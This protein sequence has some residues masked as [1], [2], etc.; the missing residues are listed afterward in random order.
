MPIY[1]SAQNGKDW[2]SHISYAADITSLAQS[3]DRIY[4][5]TD[6]KLFIYNN[7][8][9]SLEEYIKYKGGNIDITH[10]AYNKKQKC[11]FLTRSDANIELLFEDG[12][13]SEIPDLKNYSSGQITDKTINSVFMDDDCAYLSTNFGFVTVNI[14]KKEIK[15]T[16]LFN[17]KFYSV[18]SYN[19]RLYATSEKGIFTVDMSENVQ[20]FINWEEFKVSDYYKENDYKFKDSDVKNIVLFQEKLHFLFPDSAVYIM[21]SSESVKGILKGAKPLVMYTSSN[22]HLMILNREKFWEYTDLSTQNSVNIN[23]LTYIIPD[24]SKQHEYWLSSSG[25]NLSQAKISENNLEYLQQY[26]TLSGP[27]SNYPFSQTMES[28]QLIVAGGG[29][30]YDRYRFPASV[31]I[32]KN[33]KW[34]NIYPSQINQESGVYT[35]DFGYAIS[36]PSNP[37]HIFA[38]SWG[39]GLYEFEDGHFKNRY[40]KT[41]TNNVIEEIQK[42]DGWTTT[43]IGGMAY[44]KNGNLWMVNSGVKNIVKVYLKNGTWEKLYYPEIDG[45]TV[46]TNSKKIY[47]DRYSNKWVISYA[48]ENRNYLLVFDDNGSIS[49]TSDDKYKTLHNGGFTDKNGN[50]ID[51]W[52]IHDI[53]EDNYGNIWLSTDIGPY[54]IANSKNITS[55]DKITLNRITIDKQTGSGSVTGLLE[56]AAVNSI[57]IDGAGRK[58]IA[59]QTSGAFLLSADNSEILEHFDTENSPLPSNNIVSLSI[60]ANGY[61]YF[62]SE[63]GLMSYR[64]G[65]T[66]GTEDFSNVYVYPNPVRPDYSGIITVTGLKSDSHIKITDVKGN[67]IIEGKS[68]GGQFIWDG[69]NAKGRRVDTGVYLVFGSTENG[70]EGVVTKIMVVK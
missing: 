21:E 17:F 64:A 23:A 16:G 52:M 47:I 58:W 11:L 43:R 33:N 53:T 12:S 34:F 19:N 5:L 44:D 35:L 8:D 9:N 20:D 70:S 4:A 68:L 55:K 41:N 36:D 38:S 28:N 13:Y 37:N 18:S 39:D 29:F 32:W 31:S 3:E 10:M 54:W 67:L 42:E 25:S 40:D 57:A 26:I 50:K 45:T 65:A 14:V 63:R 24:E 7:S 6:G 27:A 2:I 51:I 60:D 69:I 56:N 46:D 49:D 1:M 66:Q 61:V 30:Y 62:G 15:E 59:T 22:D 48:G